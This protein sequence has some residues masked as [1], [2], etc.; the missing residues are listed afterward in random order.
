MVDTP[1][2]QAES[3]ALAGQRWPITEAG[4]RVGREPENEVHVDDPAV[5][6]QHARVLLHNGAV[7]VQDA[8]SRNGVFVNGERV[9]DH[10][11]VKPGDKVTV[12]THLFRVVMD[13]D[14]PPPPVAPPPGVQVA[15]PPP[16]ARRKGSLVPW[17]LGGMG[18]ALVAALVLVFV[19][20]A[21]RALG[22]FG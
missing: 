7:W 11:Q 12:G 13:A 21:L 3:G 18:L 6:R 19:V 17:L 20:V 1:L 16:P 9:G 5:S 15:R 10:K 22:L 4:V 14:G 8:G 2:L